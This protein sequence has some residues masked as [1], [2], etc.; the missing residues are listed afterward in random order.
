MFRRRTDLGN[1]KV[2]FLFAII[3]SV[4]PLSA[5]G[6]D[7]AVH[8]IST[9]LSGGQL[10]IKDGKYVGSFAAFFSEASKRSGVPIEYRIVPWVRAVKE[11]ERS[12]NLLL[13]SPLWN[14][15]YGYL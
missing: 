2:S 15:P 4:T 7:N 11:T 8:L 5:L 13:L 1:V 9:E 14:G 12:D 6:A 3:L 10:E